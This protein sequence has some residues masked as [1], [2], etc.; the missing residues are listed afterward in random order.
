MNYKLTI[1]PALEAGQFQSVHLFETLAEMNAAAN[2]TAD[3]LLFLQDQATLMDDYSNMFIKEEK[4]G[5]D[6]VEIED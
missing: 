4:D 2:T 1:F 5:L 3:M 6:W